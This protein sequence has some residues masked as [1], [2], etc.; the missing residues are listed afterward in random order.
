M[1][2]SSN[3]ITLLQTFQ[4]DGI[5]FDSAKEIITADYYSSSKNQEESKVIKNEQQ[6]LHEPVNKA[7]TK[8]NL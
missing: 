3:K 7:T 5:L 8:E 2:D 4:T 6:Q 1:P